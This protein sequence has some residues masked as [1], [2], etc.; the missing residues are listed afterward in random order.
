MS[1]KAGIQELI[2]FA[3]H[4]FLDSGI[5]RCDELFFNSLLSIRPL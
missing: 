5:R 4:N 3:T 2:D 1:A